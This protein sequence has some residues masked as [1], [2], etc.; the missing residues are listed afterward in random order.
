LA[1]LRRD[2]RVV[3]CG[4]ISQYN[5]TTAIKGPSNYLSLLVN[6]ATMQ[7]MVVF[8][9]AD[10]YRE[11]GMEMGKWMMEG[12]LNT[13]ETIYEGIENFQS[14][15]ERLFTGDKRGKLLLKVK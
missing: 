6:R 7:G 4:A 11:A 15:Y 12:K 10:R 14:T 1:R 8:D 3:I 2:A 13:E 5:N 9:Y